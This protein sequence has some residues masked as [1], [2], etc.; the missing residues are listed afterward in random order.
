MNIFLSTNTHSSRLPFLSRIKA[1][2]PPLMSF[3]ASIPLFSL[4]PIA[5]RLLLLTRMVLFLSYSIQA[6]NW[7]E[8]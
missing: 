6:R 1:S 4:F 5:P 2:P 3:D 8:R 7:K